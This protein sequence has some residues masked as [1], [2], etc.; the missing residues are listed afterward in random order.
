MTLIDGYKIGQDQDP[1]DV[2]ATQTPSE[3]PD[4]E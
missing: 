3:R 2:D 1:V 4:Y